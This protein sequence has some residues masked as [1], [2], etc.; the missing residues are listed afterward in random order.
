MPKSSSSAGPSHPP[1]YTRLGI[2]TRRPPPRSPPSSSLTRRVILYDCQTPGHI[3]HT[4]IFETH[5]NGAPI[6]IDP[7]GDAERLAAVR[8]PRCP[9]P[10]RQRVMRQVSGLRGP[11]E[12]FGAPARSPPPADMDEGEEVSRPNAFISPKSLLTKDGV[13]YKQDRE[14]A[15]AVGRDECPPRRPP[16]L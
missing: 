11:A 15:G 2:P 13:V 12:L 14:G 16:R 4:Y 7:S 6:P 9:L 8:V 5:L 3:I 1:I 10:A